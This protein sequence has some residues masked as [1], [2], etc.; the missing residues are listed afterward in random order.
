MPRLVSAIV[1]T[2]AL[3][4]AAS[5]AIS[6]SSIDD[7]AVTSEGWMI[8]NNGV[9][10]TR[11]SDDGPDGQPGILTHFS[12]GGGSNG[13]WIMRSSE[14]DWLG[15][16]TAAGVTAINLQ[17]AAVSG[18]D[19]PLYFAFDGPGGWFHTAGQVISTGDGFVPLTF[20]ITP[21][22]LTHVAASGGTGNPADTLAD[23]T[24]ISVI[25][26]PGAFSYTSR[27]G[28][29]RVDR[30]TNEIALDDI[31]AVPEPA[32][33]AALLGLAGCALRRRRSAD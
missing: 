9:Q 8:G 20:D 7:F 21:G 16:Y 25:A 27:G 32:V 11:D 13:R 14:A 4:A 33:A 28:F 15:D 5:A 2:A 17:V 3:P 29:I 19:V 1:L 6:L 24:E 18:P 31:T 12:D 22:G 26:G 10:P 30:S 23:V